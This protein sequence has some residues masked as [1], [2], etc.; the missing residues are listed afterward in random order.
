MQ[1]HYTIKEAAIFAGKSE[2]TIK[3]LI[4]P[5]RE[6]ASSA[7]REHLLPSPKQYAKL[8]KSGEPFQWQMSEEFLRRHFPPLD[9]AGTKPNSQSNVTPDQMKSITTDKLV[10]AL[11]RTIGILEGQLNEK[12]RQINEKDELINKFGGMA[13]ELQKKLLELP[14]AQANA[15]TTQSEQ[16]IDADVVSPKK[17]PPE[18][19]TQPTIKPTFA[20]RHLPT[21]KRILQR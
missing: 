4:A 5:I 20:E 3:R 12:D 21:F 14:V 15:S 8:K 19:S 1:K 10:E 18:R 13:Q 2:S 11:N 16:G 9:V 17:T 6:A 7:D